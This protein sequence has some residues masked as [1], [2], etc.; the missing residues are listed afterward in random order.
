MIERQEITLGRLVDFLVDNRGKTPPISEAGYELLEV[1]SIS[2]ERRTPDYSKVGKFVSEETFRNWFRKGHPQ[3]G[4]I[5]VPTVGTIGNVAFVQEARG[6]IAQNLIALR[7]K[8]GIDSKYVYYFMSSPLGKELILN[9][10]IG[11]VQP[12]I[13]VPHLLDI[14]IPLA[15]HQEQKAIA[16]VLSSLDDKIDLLHRQNKTLEAMAKILFRQWFVEEAGEDWE[17][18]VL[19]DLMVLQRGFYLPSQARVD[20]P[21]PIYAASGYSGGHAEFKVKGPGVTTG[22]SGMLGKVF[23]V[24]EDFWPLNT[25]LYVK[26]FRKGT[27]LFSYFLL[28]TLDLEAFNAGSAVPTLN[29]NHVH[30]EKLKIPPPALILRFEGIA[31]PLMKKIKQ[32]RNQINSL[33]KLRD[34]LLPKLMSGEV[35]VTC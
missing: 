26:E 20:G 22:R 32:N 4:D 23:F 19:E 12:S 9:L 16:A 2:Q 25:S 6:A 33:E 28:Q 34:I 27:P 35:R 11:G 3:P 14:P 10:D 31:S 13:K 8:K 18:G 24:F 1:N 7:L 21:Y 30:E 29:R 5:L 17:D 15:N